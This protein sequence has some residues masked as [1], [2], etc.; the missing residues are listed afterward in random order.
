MPRTTCKIVD[1][2]GTEYWF[3]WS[4]VVDA[5]VW[6]GMTLEDFKK[7]YLY[8]YGQMAKDDMDKAIE[9]ANQKG[10]GFRGTEHTLDWLIKD[11]RAGYGE[12]ELTKEE[13]IEWYCR[14][15]ENPPKGVG[16]ERAYEDENQ[17]VV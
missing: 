7:E 8:Q 17:I 1:T 4:T 3:M 12:T 2:D 6:V 10:C 9:L 16:K 11:N 15:K 14:K 5:P 13:I